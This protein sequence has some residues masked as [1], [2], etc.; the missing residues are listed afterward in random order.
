M[1][2]KLWWLVSKDLVSECRARRVWPAMLLL[3][4]LVALT[5]SVQMD[6]PP[7]EQRRIIGGLLWLAI[8]F[9][10]TLA[11]DRSLAAERED[12]CWE[13]LLLYPVSST[14][15][16]LAKVA[17][18]VVALAALQCVLIPLFAVLSDVP[19]L[20]RPGPIILI[21]LLGNLG[22]SAL[23]T[24]LSALATA[25]RHGAYLLPVLALPMAIPVVLAAAE[26]TR[27]TVENDLGDAWWQWVRLLGAFAVIFVTAGIALFDF[28]VED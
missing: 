2:A 18:N 28:A 12:G 23:A 19:L 13:G 14:T 24:L 8:F 5:F 7:Q 20:A 11:L 21:A 10:G 26:A 9:A 4:L 16:Y 17:V 15:I 6:L 25:V 22:I 1:A 27:L 3:G